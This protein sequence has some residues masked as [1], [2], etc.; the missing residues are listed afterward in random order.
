MNP[1]DNN[2]P[3]GVQGPQYPNSVNGPN[4]PYNPYNQNQYNLPNGNVPPVGPNGQPW[5]P[6][7]PPGQNLYQPPQGQEQ[8]PLWMPIPEGEP[9]GFFGFGRSKKRP[10]GTWESTKY[11]ADDAQA[12][13]D[14]KYSIP[15]AFMQTVYMFKTQ[16][17]LYSKRKAIYIVL[18]MAVLIPII[19][20]GIKDLFNLTSLTEAS[21]SG[22]VGILLSML[23]F[24]LGLFTAFL[25][26]S[27][28]P[29]EFIERSA[30]MNM[31]LPMSRTSFCIG[32]Y[33]AG[34]VIT[35]G[36]FIFAYGMAIAGAMTTYDYFDEEA[37]GLSFVMTTLAILIYTSFSFSMGCLL[38]RGASILS[39]I[40][41][42]FVFPLLELYL[43]MNDNISLDTFMMMPNLLP[44]MA[45]MTLGSYFTGSPVG[46]INLLIHVIDP[47][48]YNLLAVSAI[49]LI[50][51]VGF[52]VLGILFVRRREM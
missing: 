44:D 6:N 43:F 45:C 18:V 28:V 30:Y 31:A 23:P 11:S 52:L 12:H 49:S 7:T 36:V 42:V 40:L 47:L 33:L 13:R 41:M 46:T 5:Q 50:W 21:G 34:L 22:M 16:M 39:L 51:T 20:M 32:K 19:Y 15:N 17:A 38:K 26:G 29:S 10:K 3:N 14:T 48:D 8:P 27:V 25:C 2:N 24:I 4:V 37:L 9:K 35:L 1:A